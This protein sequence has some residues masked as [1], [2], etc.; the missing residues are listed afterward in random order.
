LLAVVRARASAGVSLQWP[1][2]TTGAV[3]ACEL[4][5]PERPA[6]N[7]DSAIATVIYL[8]NLSIPRI[9]READ[10]SII[11][12]FLSDGIVVLALDYAHDAKAVSPELAADLLKLREHIGGKNP[13]LLTDR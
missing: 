11:A 10:D 2:A 6:F 8:K 7:S 4:H 1:S 13:T 5:V 9:G 12:D 3:I